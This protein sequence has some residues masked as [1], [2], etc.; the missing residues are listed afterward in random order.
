MVFVCFTLLTTWWGFLGVVDV[1]SSS[2]GAALGGA[3]VE[4]A[5]AIRTVKVHRL[6]GAE[7]P[8]GRETLVARHGRAPVRRPAVDVHPRVRLPLR[9]EHCVE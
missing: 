3:V 9:G 8:A 4:P 2:E 6:A 1:V 5:A 7:R